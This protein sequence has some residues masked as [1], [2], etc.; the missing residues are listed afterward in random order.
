MAEAASCPMFLF[1]STQQFSEQD[2]NTLFTGSN[3]SSF[4][5][6]YYPATQKA[7]GT[8]HICGRLCTTF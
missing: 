2:L 5:Y 1:R 6:N 8:I 3:M 4:V 7:N